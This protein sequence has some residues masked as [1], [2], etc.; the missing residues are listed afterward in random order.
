[1]VV[2]NRPDSRLRSRRIPFSRRVLLAPRVGG[3]R[4]IEQSFDLSLGGMFVTSMLPLDV[5]E[6]VDL[7]MPVDSLR[8]QATA[9]V[10][11]VRGSM[12]AKDEPAGT[13]ITF[14]DLNQNQK[15]LIHREISNYIRGGGELKTGSPPPS[16]RPLGP[17]ARRAAGSRSSRRWRLIAAV[18]VTILATLMLIILL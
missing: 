9:K 3:E 5:G 13:A 12:I 7:E 18:A 4:R 17:S 6:V 10:V 16:D 8:F 15:K 14:I 1:M 2:N 11:W